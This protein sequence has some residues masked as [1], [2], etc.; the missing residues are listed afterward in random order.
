MMTFF[1]LSFIILLIKIFMEIIDIIYSAPLSQVQGVNYVNNSFVIGKNYFVNNNLKLGVIVSP[2]EVFVC[3]EHECLDTIGV[4]HTTMSYRRKR[5]FRNILRV[6]FTSKLLPGSLVKYFF[7]V[8]CPAKNAALRYLSLER[9]S[10]YILFQGIFE[11]YYYFKYVGEEKKQVKTVWMNHGDGV[12]FSMEKPV[13]P[14]IFR[15]K[16]LANKLYYA[17]YNF[18]VNRLDKIVF[19]S[20]KAI[21]TCIDIDDSKKICIY[22]GEKDLP[23]VVFKKNQDITEIVCVGSINYRKGQ[24]LLIQ[25]LVLLPNHIREN[26]H[27]NL[28][29]GGPQ[30]Q[31][32]KKYVE[33][34]GLS[35]FVKFWGI[36][37]DVP[38]I[39]KNMDVFCLPSSNEGMPM[40]LIEAMRQ[41]LYILGTDTGGIK[42]MIRPEYGKII[43]RDPRNIAEKIVEIVDNHLVTEES[44]KASR[45][46][47]E[48]NFTLKRNIDSFSNMFNSL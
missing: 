28:I 41:G 27:V 42:E 21:K 35:R 45:K 20:K 25:S 5:L 13:F 8:Y 40:V 16:W 17:K 12:A 47:F 30:L 32:I 33:N 11:A 14:A 48:D 37:N 19:L 2:E 15:Y 7:N 22:N 29:G 1:I 44:R 34:N 6:L 43:T 46:S 4:G 9:N 31:K 26:I 18:A 24:D 23:N 3:E 38:E 10:K 36:R 39:L